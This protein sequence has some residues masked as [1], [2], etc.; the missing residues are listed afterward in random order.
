MAGDYII[1]RFHHGGT[2]IKAPDPNNIGEREMKVTP[3]DKD[4]FSVVGLINYSKD[5]GNQ[6]L[7]EHVENNTYLT[8][9]EENSNLGDD[10]TI[11]PSDLESSESELDVIPEE[12]DSELDDEYRALRGDEDYYSSSDIGS[13]DSRDELDVLAERGVDLPARRKS[14]KL[15]FDPDCK[16]T[17][18][19][20]GTVFENAMQF[21]KV[22]QSY[23]I[24]YKVQLKL[25]PNE[26]HRIRVKCKSKGLCTWELYASTDRDFRD[27]IVKE[28]QPIH[29]CTTKNKNKLC[30]SKY[31]AH[32]YKDRIIS[33]PNIKLWEIKEWVRDQEGLYVGRTICYRA[34]CMVLKQFMGIDKDTKPGKNLFV[35]F[36]VCFD[37]LKRGWLEGCRKIIGFDGYFLKGLCKET[38]HSWT[39]FIENIISDLDLGDGVG[40]TVMSDMQKGLVSA[41]SEL[42]PNAEH[43]MCARHIWSNWAKN[44][45]GEERRMQFWKC[46]KS[47]YEIKFK[48]EIA[49]M[50]KLGKKDI[51]EDLLAY[52]KECWCRAYFSTCSKCDAVENNMCETFNSWIVGPRHKS[53]I[54]MLEE[55]RH[56]IMNRHVDMRRFVETWITDISPMARLILEENKEL[57]RKCKVLWNGDS[58]F[59]IGDGDKRFIVDLVRR[60]CTCRTWQLRGIPC[61][62]VVCAFYHLD[63]EP[64]NEV[65]D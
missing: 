37:A 53:I 54:T 13:D 58:G 65:E 7:I 46:A 6:P 48:E 16:I 1:F 3:I 18:F 49:N 25:T 62:H 17:I 4:H 33:Q 23:A 60:T 45:R 61:A 59:E 39:W 44:W 35:F 32:E 21:R 24:E 22:V 41:I 43:R 52:N 10:N 5:M 26:K 11:L 56:K 34:K 55:I 36:Y 14:K 15:R 63:Q 8:R 30:T 47:S 31:I 19:E 29:K 28:Y 57:S 27:F 9:E 40:L 64:E 50:A 51:C 42:L 2:F 38:K 12:D 20:L